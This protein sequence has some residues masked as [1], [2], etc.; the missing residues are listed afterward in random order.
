MNRGPVSGSNRNTS[1]TKGWPNRR[2]VGPS[3]TTTAT[4][5][6]TVTSHS[7]QPGATQ[8]PLGA[9]EITIRRKMAIATTPAIRLRVTHPHPTS[10]PQILFET[11]LDSGEQIRARFEV[12]GPMQNLDQT[13]FEIHAS[14][15]RMEA[16]ADMPRWQWVFTEL[17]EMRRVAAISRSERS[18]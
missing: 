14:S 8:R 6:G 16:R 9:T 15:P 5:T 11:A 12:V 2:S 10:M 1:A 4:W 13:L 3:V 17:G 18:R 7:D